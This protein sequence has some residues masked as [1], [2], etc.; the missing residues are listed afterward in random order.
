MLPVEADIFAKC[1]IS[2]SQY[3]FFLLDALH[4]ITA[5]L[6]RHIILTITTDNLTEASQ[7]IGDVT[8]ARVMVNWFNRMLQIMNGDRECQ[9]LFWRVNTFSSKGKETGAYLH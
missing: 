9:L 8:S 3:K 1:K 2:L 7:E 4:G 5:Q 6:E